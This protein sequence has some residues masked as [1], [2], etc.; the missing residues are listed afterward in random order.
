MYNEVDWPDKTLAKKVICKRK[1]LEG[2]LWYTITGYAVFSLTSSE[3]GRCLEMITWSG[4]HAAASGRHGWRR[5][6]CGRVLMVSSHGA[7]RAVSGGSGGVLRRRSHRSCGPASCRQV[8]VRPGTGQV[9]R[10]QHATVG[11]RH[12]ATRRVET[13]ARDLMV[14]V[15]V[16]VVHL[17][18]FRTAGRLRLDPRRCYFLQ[19]NCV[20]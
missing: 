12:R 14:M 18:V 17:A 8:S 11:S 1:H 3:H 2:K 5:R 6:R 13:A 4:N 20:G 15:Q 9:T 10:R 16:R 7:V 19:F